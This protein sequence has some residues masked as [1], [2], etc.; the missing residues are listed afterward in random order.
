MYGHTLA[1]YEAD[2]PRYT[3][4]VTTLRPRPH[5]TTRGKILDNNLRGVGLGHVVRVVRMSQDRASAVAV[6]QLF[7]LICC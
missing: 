2:H 7:V 1:S 5:E 6:S 4:S 3:V